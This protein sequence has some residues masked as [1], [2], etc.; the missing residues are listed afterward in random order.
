[1]SDRD[2]LAIAERLQAAPDADLSQTQRTFRLV[3]E[4]EAEVT[5][6]DFHQYFGNSAGVHAPAAVDALAAIG[7]AACADIAG[8]A[9]QLVG[10]DFPWAAENGARRR[11]LRAGGD[12]LMDGLDAL[13][14]AFYGYPDDLAALLQAHVASHPADFPT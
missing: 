11:A 7:A 10:A 9:V 14:S 5:N 2:L 6:G 8:R 12:A 4:L 1:M 3:W 13:D